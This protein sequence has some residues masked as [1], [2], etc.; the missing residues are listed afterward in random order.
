MR[1]KRAAI[2][3]KNGDDDNC[4][5]YASTVALNYQNIEDHPE[6]ISNTEP[7]IDKYYWKGITPRQSR[8]K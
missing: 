5:Q 4:F 3:P 8:R 6:R 2:K 1:N 7:F